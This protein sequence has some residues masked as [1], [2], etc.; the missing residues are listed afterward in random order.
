MTDQS[1]QQSAN[2]P[3]SDQDGRQIQ[4]AEVVSGSNMAG[5]AVHAD[6]VASPQKNNHNE[7]LG[8]T[9][10]DPTRSLLKKWL[11]ETKNPDSNTKRAK[12]WEEIG[13]EVFERKALL[14]AAARDLQENN[15]PDPMRLA[16]TDIFVE[17]AQG[18]LNSRAIKLY[19]WGVFTVILALSILVTAAVWLVNTNVE[20][21]LGISSPSEN[22]TSAYLT[23][24]IIK[25]TS[26]GAFV[27]T[28]VYILFS[29]CRALLHEATV[30]YNR[31]H[32]LRFGRLFIYLM[33]DK[34]TREDLEAVF[35]WNG[36]YSSAFRDIKAEHV[37]KSPLMKLLETPADTLR[38]LLEVLNR[39]RKEETGTD[40][41][42][43]REPKVTTN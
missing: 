35:N 36:E 28:A 1:L 24:V 29:L 16:T 8:S 34:L 20:R 43:D 9:L 7:R 23:I 2:G 25:S 17:K 10:E 19:C 39:P 12:R 14:I 42:K 26:A 5:S 40:G 15:I 4:N 30:L 32:S 37:T 21:I 41:S 3:T 27:A 22:V 13:W 18:F 11:T 38:L 33:S 31:R 6:N